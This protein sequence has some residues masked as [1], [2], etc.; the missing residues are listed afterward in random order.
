MFCLYIIASKYS[1]EP[2]SVTDQ[3]ECV[4]Q[5]SNFSTRRI[6][7]I[8]IQPPPRDAAYN[9]CDCS[10]RTTY[11]VL[12]AAIIIKNGELQHNFYVNDFEHKKINISVNKDFVTH[13]T[14]NGSIGHLTYPVQISAGTEEF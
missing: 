6:T 11:A 2:I 10:V 12:N 9:G 5:P 1:F 8:T 3:W 14:P 13:V 4:F 7:G